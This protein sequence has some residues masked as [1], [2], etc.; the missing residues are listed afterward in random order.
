METLLIVDDDLSLL[1]SLKMHFEDIEQDGAPRFHVVTATSAAA[2]AARPRR[3]R[4]PAWS[5]S[6]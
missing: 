1:E 4:S 3:S 6:T 5:S 2:G